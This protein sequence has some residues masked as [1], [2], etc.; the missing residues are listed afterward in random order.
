A[1]AVYLD[2]LF[3][4]RVEVCVIESAETFSERD[5]DIDGKNG[6]EVQFSLTGDNILYA[7]ISSDDTVRSIA[8]LNAN[9]TLFI[10]IDAY[11]FSEDE[12]EQFLNNAWSDS[13]MVI[14]PQLRKSLCIL[15]K[16][17][18]GRKF[19]AFTLSRVDKS[20][21]V[22]KGYAEW[23]IP[24][25]GHWEASGYFLQD[26]EEFSVA[27]FDMDYAHNAQKIHGMF[28]D[29]KRYI[30][31][32]NNNHPTTVHETDAWY[33]KNLTNKEISFSIKSFIVAVDTDINS[34]IEEDELNAFASELT[35]WEQ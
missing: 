22:E 35:I 7:H 10:T 15:P 31:S 18:E 17:R 6:T 32:S 19:A 26:D 29:E 11:D 14:Y 20:Y 23:A 12:F 25:V 8:G 9:K 4:K 24:I 16:T 13:A 1:K 21:A 5:F 30:F 34:S 27:F 28:M 33:L 3:G 2:D